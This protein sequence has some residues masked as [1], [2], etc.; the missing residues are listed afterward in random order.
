[1]KKTNN[2]TRQFETIDFSNREFLIEMRQAALLFSKTPELAP[3]WERAL[4]QLADA[5]DRVDAMV[6]RTELK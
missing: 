6:A 5:F 1:M 3:S 2:N 4:I